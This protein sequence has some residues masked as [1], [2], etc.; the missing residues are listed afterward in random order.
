MSEFSVRL[1]P[2]SKVIP[3]PN[4][5]RLELVYLEGMA[6]QFVAQKDTLNVGQLVAYIP[7]DALVPKGLAAL[8][9]LP[10]K[11]EKDAY[12]VRP[13]KLRGARSEGVLAALPVLSLDP[14]L[15]Y[16]GMDITEALGIKKWEP[17]ETKFNSHPEELQALPIGMQVYDIENA[18][19]YPEVFEALV[20]NIRQEAVFEVMG[21]ELVKGLYLTPA[22]DV[23]ITE[24]LEG[25][26]WWAR[27]D[28]DGETV[29]VGQRRYEIKTPSIFREEVDDYVEYDFSKV[30]PYWRCLFEQD[31]D[32]FLSELGGYYRGHSIT[33]RGEM[34]GAAIQGNYYKLPGNE[35]RVYLFEIELD[36]EP[37]D[38]ITAFDWFQKE[39]VL[40][41]PIIYQGFLSEFAATVDE[42]VVKAHGV[43]SIVVNGNAPIR[44]GIVVKPTNEIY[45]PVIGRLILKVRDPIYLEEV[46]D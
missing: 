36:G 43:S 19:R 15:A 41:A 13:V 46:H 27:L 17:Q 2:V 22:D 44:E 24:K 40:Y 34:I 45:N 3:H 20:N 25:T 18:Q 9:G 32:S 39:K 31:L 38:A 33:I 26:H 28:R 14:K 16:V 30:N 42:L 23:I 12:R 37:M 5:D 1:L 21:N 29:H 8:L 7:T 35:R 4:A 10:I 11:P 6:Y